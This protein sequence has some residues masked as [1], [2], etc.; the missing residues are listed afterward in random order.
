VAHHVE[1]TGTFVDAGEGVQT[2]E[3]PMRVPA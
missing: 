1:A 3:P 2:I